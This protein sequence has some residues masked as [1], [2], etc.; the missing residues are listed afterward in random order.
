MAI[1]EFFE[2]PGALIEEAGAPGLAVGL[3][4]VLLAPVLIP[5]VAGIGKPVAKAA[6]KGGIALFEKTK[7]AF[8]EVG[9]SV[10]DLVA[11]ARAEMAEKQAQNIRTGE[12][13]SEPATDY[14]G[15]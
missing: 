11:E 10:E 1:G 13:H 8:A 9:E 15:S 12:T 3:G 6:I 14:P 7:G 4:A 5:F 2:E